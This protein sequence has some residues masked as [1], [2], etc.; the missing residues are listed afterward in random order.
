MREE[1]RMVLSLIAM[2]RMTAA[3]A[4][5]LLAAWTADRDLLW[6]AAAGVALCV[7]QGIVHGLGPGFAH[8]VHAMAPGVHSAVEHA[9]ALIQKGLGGMR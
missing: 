3:E 8:W 9:A 6:M 1:R 7:G 5:R 2:G 4:E